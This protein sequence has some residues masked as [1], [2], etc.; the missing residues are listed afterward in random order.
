MA[1]HASPNSKTIPVTVKITREEKAA[2]KALAAGHS[3]PSAG[4]G[5]RKLI[6]RFNRG[7]A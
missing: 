7:A 1:R 2:L 3:R 5:I 6:D 4:L